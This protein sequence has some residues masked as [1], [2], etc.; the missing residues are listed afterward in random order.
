MAKW[1]EQLSKNNGFANEEEK[2]YNGDVE[3]GNK[4]FLGLGLPASGKSSLIT[5]RLLIENKAILL[6]S[7]EAKKI[8]P[9]T[10]MSR[11]LKRFITQNRFI[12]LKFVANYGN[13]S[14]RVFEEMKGKVDEYVKW[15]NEVKQGEQ[16][17]CIDKGSCRENVK[18]LGERGISYR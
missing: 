1:V 3:K 16:P 7:D 12:N 18:G 4:A 8:K 17:V 10:S 5:N 14:S 13:E 2:V 11:M 9:K 15:S 6:D